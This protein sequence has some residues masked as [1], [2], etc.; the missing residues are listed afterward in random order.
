M[1]NYLV[2]Y[3]DTG[4]GIRRQHFA[5]LQGA[6]DFARAAARAYGIAVVQPT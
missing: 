6:I 5:T 2:S 3:E 1:H 4:S